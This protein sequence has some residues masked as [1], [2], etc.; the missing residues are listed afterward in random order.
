[1]EYRCNERPKGINA[2]CASSGDPNYFAS[3]RI[4]V[5][6]NG[7][8]AEA[9]AL[10]D[11][12][13]K[14][15]LFLGYQPASESIEVL[16]YNEQAGRFEFQEVTD[17]G[18]AD[19][20]KVSYAE[21]TV[22]ATCHQGAA[23]IFATALWSETNGSESVAK[24]LADLGESFHGVAVRQGVDGPDFFD[25]STDRA[26]LLPVG[27]RLWQDG[28]QAADDPAGCRGALLL[29][30]LRYRLG[31]SRT[32]P[33]DPED[34][35]SALESQVPDGIWAADP[36]LPNRDPMILVAA[37]T[38]PADA[39][40]PTGQFDPTVDRPPVPL[41]Q[42]G[43]SAAALVAMIFA[44]VD[45]AWLD[46]RL[47]ALRLPPTQTLGGPC[48]LG[49]VADK[50]IRF[51]CTAD[52]KALSLDGFVRMKDG[53]VVGGRIDRL[54][55]GGQTAVRRL[56][57]EPGSTGTADTLEL[58]LREAGQSLSAR[59]ATGELLSTLTLALS[60]SGVGQATISVIDDMA[61]L[62]TAIGSL[63][64]LADDSPPLRRPILAALDA[65][66]SQKQN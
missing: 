39:I 43:Q 62:A 44:N 30:A 32:I 29:T 21:R 19:T 28:C 63:S 20:A 34:V 11:P 46:E 61:V 8:S 12:L 48:K 45:I 7:Q 60:P 42:P 52:D 35:S 50:E 3:P 37:N 22:C 47:A 2:V 36:D 4:V 31:G 55:L 6:V 16:S 66:L 33:V 15:R 57:I 41:W 10:D 40:E 38:P 9:D 49:F 65:Q 24:S 5:A 17:Y 13:L 58:T 64:T 54:S 56:F 18:S 26:N 14:D 51:S 23:P 1:A 25:Q 59:L 53:D 27:A